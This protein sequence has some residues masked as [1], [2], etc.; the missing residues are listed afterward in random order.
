M[1]ARRPGK[2]LKRHLEDLERHAGSSDEAEPDK[3]Q[4]SAGG[5]AGKRQAAA[6]AQKPQ[7]HPA[8]PASKALPQG[9]F[10][11]PMDS[12]DELVFTTPV[13]DD[14]ERSH[15]PPVFS[16][17]AYPAPDKLLLDQYGS[18]PPYPTM[19]AATAAAAD[20]YF[21]YLSAAS[22]MPATL[23]SMTHFN[24]GDAMK[25]ESFPASDDGIN[26]YLNYSFVPG[27]D[28]NLPSPYDPSNPH[29]SPARLSSL[30]A[31]ASFAD[32]AWQTPP[33]SH[34][35]ENSAT[36]SETGS[37]YPTTPLSMPGS[38]GMIQ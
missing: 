36:C 11:P 2:K 35:F 1:E 31:C 18:A 26:L 30:A 21:S 33:L 32:P 27:V 9:Q 15:T 4:A 3:K 38:P 8:A 17:T 29:V 24:S 37:E 34:S 20:P 5:K 16:Y 12:A 10:T 13:Y 7:Q 28:V 14:R 23:P 6:K 22:S 19:S 25:R